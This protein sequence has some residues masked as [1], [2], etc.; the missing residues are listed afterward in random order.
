MGAVKVVTM[1]WV[2]FLILVILLQCST[3]QGKQQKA[4]DAG[5]ASLHKPVTLPLSE[6]YNFIWILDNENLFNLE[7]D[8]NS[9]IPFEAP[10]KVTS[11]FKVAIKRKWN[12][13]IFEFTELYFGGNS[14]LPANQTISCTSTNVTFTSD[15]PF[16]WTTCE[17]VPVTPKD[18]NASLANVRKSKYQQVNAYVPNTG[19]QMWILPVKQNTKLTIED[20]YNANTTATLT[21]NQNMW[22][23]ASLVY[24]DIHTRMKFEAIVTTNRP[25]VGAFGMTQITNV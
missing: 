23:D 14:G 5:T 11:W 16:I 2:F 3:A 7:V 4:C 9:E 8:F 20:S 25:I 13:C 12:T 10:V 24:D 18:C 19:L 17:N 15:K 6:V 1:K 22:H 21:V